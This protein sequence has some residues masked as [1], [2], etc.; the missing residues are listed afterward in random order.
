MIL[1]NDFM[2]NNLRTYFLKEGN[3]TITRFS[4]F[5]P[6]L[7]NKNLALI[8][9]DIEGSEGRVIESGIELINKYHVPFIFLEFNPSLLIE[10][11]TNPKNLLQLFI[12]NGYRITFDGFFSK[13]YVSIEQLIKT[14]QGHLKLYFIYFGN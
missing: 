7:L 13:S 12:D 14:Y 11:G 6:Y 3:I 9:I 2:N 1:C 5:I 8:K 4:N 10:H